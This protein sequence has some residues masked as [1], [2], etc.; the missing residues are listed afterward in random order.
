[1]YGILQSTKSY[2]LS[3]A[4]GLIFDHLRRALERSS[5]NTCHFSN[6]TI[7]FNW[8]EMD[9]EW[10]VPVYATHDNG[11]GFTC[12]WFPV[13]GLCKELDFA[14]DLGHHLDTEDYQEFLTN[15]RYGDD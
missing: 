1:M 4:E 2:D 13:K 6:S 9:D 14:V 7:Y 11:L 5:L 12:G 8:E 3:N 15:Y 10:D